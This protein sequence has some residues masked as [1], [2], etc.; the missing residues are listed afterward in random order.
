[1]NV[2]N[3]EVAQFGAAVME[4]Y[5]H[6]KK[7]VPAD[8]ATWL[9]PSVITPVWNNFLHSLVHE[10][11][12]ELLEKTSVEARRNK[13]APR[14]ANAVNSAYEIQVTSG[15]NKNVFFKG[16]QNL[17]KLMV[18]QEHR[19]SVYMSTQKF[20]VQNHQFNGGL[21]ATPPNVRRMQIEMQASQTPIY[22]QNFWHQK[23]DRKKLFAK[24]EVYDS[25]PREF[26]KYGP[27]QSYYPRWATRKTLEDLDIRVNKYQ[28]EAPAVTSQLPTYEPVGRF[29]L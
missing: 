10:L 16:L 28:N 5:L 13:Y 4:Y 8:L 12:H 23:F 22:Q 9:H 7:Q 25:K 1:M 19:F 26:E 29:L 14:V 2:T 24:G 17:L 3:F 6:Q 18:H 21:S 27:I 20:R 15:I 11:W